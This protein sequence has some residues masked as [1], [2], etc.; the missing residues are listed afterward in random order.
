MNIIINKRK[1][2]LFIVTLTMTG[3]AQSALLSGGQSVKHC[4][5]SPRLASGLIFVNSA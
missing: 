3:V 1:H 4:L 2:S 5:E